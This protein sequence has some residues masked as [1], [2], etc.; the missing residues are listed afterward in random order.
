MIGKSYVAMKLVK[1]GPNWND[2]KCLLELHFKYSSTLI[3]K[4]L[5]APLFY[6]HEETNRN[7]TFSD[8]KNVIAKD[9]F[10]Q[11]MVK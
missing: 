5:L 3:F 11:E 7:L 2:I 9:S 6:L 10:S 8:L 4:S 1:P